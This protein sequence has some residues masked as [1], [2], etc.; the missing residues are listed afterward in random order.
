M[1][2]NE[3]LKLYFLKQMEDPARKQLISASN[4]H[5]SE[6]PFSQNQ[7]HIIVLA[8]IADECLTDNLTLGFNGIPNYRDIELTDKGIAWLKMEEL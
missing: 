1:N 4:Y 7:K 6:R 3:S 8:L 5:F 2:D